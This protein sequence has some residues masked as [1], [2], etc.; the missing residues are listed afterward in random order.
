MVVKRSVAGLLSALLLAGAAQRAGHCN[1]RS[2]GDRR[3]RSRCASAW[4]DHN[5]RLDDILVIARKQ[6]QATAACR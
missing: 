2:R 3:V 4:M 1:L 6:L 5:L